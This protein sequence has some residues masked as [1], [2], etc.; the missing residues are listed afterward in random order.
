M[1][2]IKG[3]LIDKGQAVPVLHC[4]HR[5]RNESFEL[6]QWTGLHGGKDNVE[7]Y[8]GDIVTFEVENASVSHFPRGGKGFIKFESG[9]FVICASRKHLQIDEPAHI[10][11]GSGYDA[12]LG[13]I[14]VIGNIYDNP[15]L[16]VE[17]E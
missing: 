2:G 6:M 11:M 5:L 1:L 9:C 13:T 12:Y 7:L 14:E 10:T 4:A 8:E 16:L 3:L 17:S 15:E